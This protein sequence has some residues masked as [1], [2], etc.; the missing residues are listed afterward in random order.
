MH[1]DHGIGRYEGLERIA[2]T[3]VQHDC[4][5]IIYSGG[6]KLFLPVE[7]I[8]LLSR[9]GKEGGEQLSSINLAVHHGRPKGTDQG[10]GA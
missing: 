3:N 7:N 9:Y 4:L 1:V 5:L 6:D 8:D 2:I 10:P